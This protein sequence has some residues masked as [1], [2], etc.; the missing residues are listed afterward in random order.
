MVA[1]EASIL[2]R[3]TLGTFSVVNS[4]LAGGPVMIR[5]T[6]IL[7]LAV[8][9][10][11][12]LAAAETSSV[13]ISGTVDKLDGQVLSVKSKDGQELSINLPDG[14]RITALANKSLD[15]IKPG[16][17]VG[18]AAVADADGKLH[19]QEVHIFPESL[20]G[21]GEGH[22]PMSGPGQTMTNATVAE[23]VRSPDGRGIKLRYPGGEQEIDVAA[24]VRV[25][26]ILPGDLSLL[27]PGAA[28]SVFA[29]KAS[30]GSLSAR[31]VQAE[32]DGVKPLM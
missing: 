27:K 28:V 16:D 7:I 10:C 5:V 31:G 1:S 20:R 4:S 13:R 21:S 30:D 18:S 23:V 12:P 2:A 17:F 19:A 6:P 22:R 24:D 15:D 11:G 32:K 29:T 3:G 26:E 14:V 8:A 25:V 9:L